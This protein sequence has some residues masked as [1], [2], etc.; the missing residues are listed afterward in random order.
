MARAKEVHFFDNEGMDWQSPDLA[1]LHQEFDWETENV[2]RGEATPIY[3]YWRNALRRLKIYN[4]SAR[5][6]MALRH[7]SFRAYSHWRME[8]SRKA[9]TLSFDDAISIGRDRVSGAPYGQHRVFSYVERGCFE[10]QIAELQELFPPQQVHFLRTDSLW[11]NPDVELARIQRFLGVENLIPARRSYIAPLKSMNTDAMTK[12]A[13]G[14]L[15]EI[16]QP[17]I[18]VLGQLTGLEFDDWQQ[19][20]YVEPMVSN[21]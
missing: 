5:I 3:T 6:L 11:N 16:F 20:D 2:L 18:A 15:D 1:P 13:R 8:V 12:R 10:H 14:Q 17:T 19:S 9:E 21:D 7:P 4:P